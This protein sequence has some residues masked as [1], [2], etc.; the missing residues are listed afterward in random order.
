MPALPLE[1][2]TLGHGV[3]S[4]IVALAAVVA[5]SY[6]AHILLSPTQGANADILGATVG[7]IAIYIAALLD[8]SLKLNLMSRLAQ[9]VIIVLIPP[10][11]LIFLV[12]GTIFLGIATP[13]EGGA[14]GAVGALVL[15]AFK[16]RLDDGRHQAGARL[17]DAAVVLRDVHPDRRARLLADLLRRQRRIFGSSTCSC[18]CPAARSA[19]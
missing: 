4:L 2:R 3:T 5:I 6:V 17:D 14:M 1:A 16:S 19:S 9:Q 10:L 12:L 7:V 13:T 8:R 18:R 15:A 11:A